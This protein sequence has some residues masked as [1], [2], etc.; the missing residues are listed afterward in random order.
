MFDNGFVPDRANAA[1]HMSNLPPGL[2]IQSQGEKEALEALRA[3]R[4]AHGGGFWRRLR[5]RLRR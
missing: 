4:K 3:E 1:N 5:A 2:P